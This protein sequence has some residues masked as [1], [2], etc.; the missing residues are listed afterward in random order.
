MEFFRMTSYWLFHF[1]YVFLF[2]FFHCC[3]CCCCCCCNRWNT[4][5]AYVYNISPSL[6][7]FTRPPR[8][9]IFFFHNLSFH[10]VQERSNSLYFT[11]FRIHDAFILCYP[12]AHA[13]LHSLTLDEIRFSLLFVAASMYIYMYTYMHTPFTTVTLESDFARER[14]GRIR[15]RRRRSRREIGTS[16]EGRVVHPT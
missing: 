15:R 10:R 14:K 4:L 2:S 12:N 7:L 1:A 6:C 13:K 9:T 8:S 3:R 16:A 11:P 5:S